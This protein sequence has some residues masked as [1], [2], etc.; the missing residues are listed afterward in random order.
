MKQAAGL[1]KSVLCGNAGN[2]IDLNG[3]LEA[4]EIMI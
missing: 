3:V 4:V 1:K 2:G